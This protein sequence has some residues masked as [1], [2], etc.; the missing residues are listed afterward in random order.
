MDINKSWMS[1][2]NRLSTQ[3][4]SGAKALAERSK[5]FINDQVTAESEDEGDEI[6]DLMA[7]IARV[8]GP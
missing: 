6:H 2:R 4:R 1:I 7:D 8:S 3:F 5:A